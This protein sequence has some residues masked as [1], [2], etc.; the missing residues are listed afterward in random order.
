MDKETNFDY[1][2]DL[3]SF[4]MALWEKLMWIYPNRTYLKRHDWFGGGFESMIE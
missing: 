3:K 4:N 1:I 2:E